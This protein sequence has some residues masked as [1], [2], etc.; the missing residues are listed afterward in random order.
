MNTSG[1]RQCLNRYFR[2]EEMDGDGLCGTYLIRWTLL[3]WPRRAYLHHFVGS[4]WA[5]DPHDHPKHF[6]SIGLWGS[7]VEHVYDDLA[8]PTLR[9]WR[10]PW[11]R[12]FPATHRHRVELPAG[13][14][15]WTVC[16]VGKPVREWGFYYRLERWVRWD[17]Y[18]WGGA[19]AE[20]KD[21]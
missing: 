4:D 19:G 3:N 15:C 8:R 16:V 18:V 20:R 5:R 17:E 2:R 13:E 10:A 1:L 9:R 12:W 21:C 6:L 11:I 14:S 7:Y